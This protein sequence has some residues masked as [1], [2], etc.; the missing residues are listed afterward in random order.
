MAPGST[1]K[2]PWLAPSLANSSVPLAASTTPVA[3]LLKV[4]LSPKT[5]VPVPAVFSR[6]PSLVIVRLSDQLLSHRLGSPVMFHVPPTWFQMVLPVCW[7]TQS[8]PL[9]LIV[10]L[11]TNWLP[12]WRYLVL[13]PETLNVAP[14][15]TVN[16]PALSTPPVHWP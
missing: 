11:L 2:L 16:A 15:S 14:A 8:P 13:P 4:I 7:A 1:L 5:V 10:P 6:R 9:Q 3:V 12:F